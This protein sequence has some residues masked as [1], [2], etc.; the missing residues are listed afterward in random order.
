MNDNIFEGMTYAEYE[1]LK[2]KRDENIAKH[3][4]D[5]AEFFEKMRNDPDFEAEVAERIR[6]GIFRHETEEEKARDAELVALWRAEKA[7]E[8]EMENRKGLKLV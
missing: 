8:Q 5:E 4:A 1:A 6:Q 2:K 7:M 3:K